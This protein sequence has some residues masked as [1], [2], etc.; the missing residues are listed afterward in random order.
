MKYQLL[1]L[2]IFFSAIAA[3]AQKPRVFFDAYCNSS[4]ANWGKG[5]IA[6]GWDAN[7]HKY[8]DTSVVENST[9]LAD[10]FAYHQLL[11]KLPEEKAAYVYYYSQREHWPAGLLHFFNNHTA[12]QIDTF[13]NNNAVAYYFTKFDQFDYNAPKGYFQNF[14]NTK[15]P[16]VITT[17]LLEIPAAENT[18]L[19]DSM[20]PTTDI[21]LPLRCY[22]ILN[23]GEWDKLGI[24]GEKQIN[25]AL[26]KMEA[27]IKT[28]NEKV[29]ES[30]YFKNTV[31]VPAL[32]NDILLQ[33]HQHYVEFLSQIYTS[34]LFD[35]A[36]KKKKAIDEVK[37]SLQFY[38]DLLNKVIDNYR[39]NCEWLM[40]AYN[41]KEYDKILLFS[42]WKLS[43]K[44]T[45]NGSKGINGA[46]L[47]GNAD[48]TLLFETINNNLRMNSHVVT[49]G[50]YDTKDGRMDNVFQDFDIWGDFKF[51][52]GNFTPL[53]GQN[54][55]SFTHYNTAPFDQL[56]Q[57]FLRKKVNGLLD[58][59][60][61]FVINTSGIYD[62]P[63]PQIILNGE[64]FNLQWTYEKEVNENT[65]LLNEKIEK[66]K[67]QLADMEKQ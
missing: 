49:S 58:A 40:K 4:L 65:D 56:P 53:P 33:N 64:K 42:K 50:A 27:F 35:L 60:F 11:K 36:S 15:M 54:M 18:G 13:L 48:H 20:R 3:T 1:L 66:I 5:D 46:Q 23:K 44:F 52:A 63:V 6:Q 24:S 19:P 17:H 39:D 62:Y 59:N 25:K 2:V 22:P 38:K 32:T 9:S 30:L 57:Y 55:A 14:T 37:Q 29:D 67:M 12:G 8:F 47:F 61:T 7:N 21:Y 34:Y 45:G 26:K 41:N 16:R 43:F 10:T 51:A 28:N 31:P